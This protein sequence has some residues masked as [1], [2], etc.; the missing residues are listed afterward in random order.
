MDAKRFDSLARLLVSTTHRRG[1]LRL[2]SVSA[3]GSV[4]AVGVGA[5]GAKKRKKK[6]TLCHE[7]QTIIV[8]KKAKKKHLRHGDTPGACPTSTTTQPPCVPESQATTCAGARCGTARNNNCGEAVACNCPTGQMCLANGSCARPCT[9]VS[10]CAPCNCNFANAE[11]ARYCG[12]PVSTCA[13]LP[14]CAGTADCPLGTHCQACNPDGSNT[15]CL[16]L[17]SG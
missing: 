5:A 14:T 2:L 4:L 8:G 15:R 16:P 13:D 7:G 3:P 12:Q 6:V 11:G 10:Q 1:A 9:Q 17:C